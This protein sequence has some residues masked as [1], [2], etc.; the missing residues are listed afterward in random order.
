M[1]SFQKKYI[2]IFWTA[3]LSVFCLDFLAK[4]WVVSET[5]EPVRIIG[6][7]FYL[8]NYQ[9]NDGIAFGID[10]PLWI[11]L[12]GSIIIIYLLLDLVFKGFLE[13]EGSHFK[14]ALTGAIIGGGIGNLVD[15]AVNGF[16]VDFIVLKP[17][18]LFNI[19]D[20]GITVG[21]VLL[22]ATILMDKRK[23]KT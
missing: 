2:I 11:Q 12:L 4:R 18:P 22:F 13:K 16:V 3:L 9:K 20:V 21:L 10:V 15:R 6:R 1:K 5:F 8:T 17:F 19:A 14:I 7:F 23:S